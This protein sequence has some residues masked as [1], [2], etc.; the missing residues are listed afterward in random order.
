VHS[1][2][3]EA[4]DKKSATVLVMLDLSAAFGFVDHQTLFK[5]LEHKFGMTA[6][7]RAW[8]RS[9]LDH[10]DWSSDQSSIACTHN[11][12]ETSSNDTTSGTT[13]TQKTPRTGL[14]V[15]QAI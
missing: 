5:R 3:A 12:S 10:K 13:A 6:Q 2:I 1:D 9:Y 7:A 15:L 8:M 4:M 14:H 11:L